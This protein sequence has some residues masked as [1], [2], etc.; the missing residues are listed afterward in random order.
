MLGLSP[1]SLVSFEQ[2]FK[3]YRVRGFALRHK[4][5]QRC[6]RNQLRRTGLRMHEGPVATND[7]HEFGA[8]PPNPN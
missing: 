6:F 4:L 2:D 5:L 8:R 1:S 3:V 7:C